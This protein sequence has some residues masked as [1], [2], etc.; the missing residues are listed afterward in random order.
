MRRGCQKQRQGGLTHTECWAAAQTERNASHC[1][2]HGFPHAATLQSQAVAPLPV[3][4][5][6]LRILVP[7]CL[8]INVGLGNFICEAIALRQLVHDGC[9]WVRMEW[10]R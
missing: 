8:F 6:V 1:M 9:G 3:P 7:D 4:H 10:R 2:A 5:Q